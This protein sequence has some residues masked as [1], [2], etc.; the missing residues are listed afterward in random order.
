MTPKSYVMLVGAPKCGTTT[1]AA[2]LGSLPGVAAPE[3]KETQYFTDFATRIWRGPGAD[4]ALRAPKTRDEFEQEYAG[5][6]EASVRIEASTDHLWCDV[7]AGN[8][9]RFANREDVGVVRIVACVRDPVSRIVSEYEHTLQLGWQTG[10]LMESLE[11]E[12]KRISEGWNP[13]FYHI[14]RSR[15]ATQL[16]RYHALFGERLWIMDTQSINAV[17]TRARL[18]RWI[19]IDGADPELP[20]ERLNERH[21]PRHPWRAAVLNNKSLIRLA[22]MVSPQGV[23]PLFRRAV[24]GRSTERYVPSAEEV[25]FIRDALSDEIRAC[26]DDPSIPTDSW[27]LSVSDKP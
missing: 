13:L 3:H 7:A 20:P 17:E 18:G 5:N 23:R 25:A 19:G 14:E 4:F 2:W 15:Y 21:V 11:A 27:D 1:L 12:T 10:S 16:A 26:L 24:A 22:R 8:I 9:A 6:P